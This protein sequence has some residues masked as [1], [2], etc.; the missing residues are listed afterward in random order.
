[1][2]AFTAAPDLDLV[3]ESVRLQPL[4]ERHSSA[5]EQNQR[6]DQ[7][8]VDALVDA[9]IYRM[10]MPKEVGGVELS[11]PKSLQLRARPRSTSVRLALRPSGDW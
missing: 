3:A 10:W 7:E 8:V 9:G 6:L 5:N 1:M 11:P 2:P 4:I